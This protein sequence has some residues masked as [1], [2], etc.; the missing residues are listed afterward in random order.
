MRNCRNSPHLMEVV[1][2]WRRWSLGK[3]DLHQAMK[4]TDFDEL[5][6]SVREGGRILRGE[7]KASRTFDYAEQVRRIRMKLGKSQG[8]FAEMIRVPI[9][10]VRNWEQG[11]RTPHGAAAALLM[12][13][14]ALPSKSLRVLQQ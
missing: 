9:A 7:K 13:V 10:T 5:I 6:E 14:E 4:K 1:R 8:E 3:I 2:H 12:L 11:R